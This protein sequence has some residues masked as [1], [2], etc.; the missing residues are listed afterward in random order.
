MET[1]TPPAAPKPAT[2]AAPAPATEKRTGDSEKT[3][4]I[5]RLDPNYR[6][7]ATQKIGPASTPPPGPEDTQILGAQSTQK[8][9]PA[10][11]PPPGPEDTQILG[12]QTTQKIDPAAAPAE[13]NAEQTQ[14]LD[15][16]IWRLQEAK[17]I[18]QGINQK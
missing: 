7:D 2:A 1:A 8:V 17:R 4:K 10:V 11:T 9:S 13:P 5:P 18:L 12:A 15:D 14:R 3:Q 16:S 6:P